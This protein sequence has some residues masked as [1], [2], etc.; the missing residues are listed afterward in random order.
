MT[1]RQRPADLGTA[2]ARRFA[3]LAAREVRT[4]RREAG[5][6]QSEAARRAGVSRSQFARLER[7][8]LP[9]PSLEQLCRASRATGLEAYF[10][11]YRGEEPVRDRS[12]LALLARFE[13]LLGPSLTMRREVPL[14]IA[15]DKRAWDAR[16]TSREG[17][18]S[19]EGESRVEDCQA[20]AR[21]IELKR[22]DD[23]GA[24][25]IILVLNK[26]AHNRDV[27]RLHREALR[28]QLPLDGW[29]IARSLRRG[30][31]PRA[32]GIILV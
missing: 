24:G 7:A 26:T 4:A 29:E 19:I 21:R 8:E 20:L 9:R 18:A 2:D 15:G 10:R 28:T 16:V 22:R 32:G 6:S 14:P 12:Q 25:V 30:E 11:L 23:P 31:I 27:L 3:E 1:V 5:I 17:T 13:A